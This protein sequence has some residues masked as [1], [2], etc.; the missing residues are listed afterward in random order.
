LNFRLYFIIRLTTCFGP[1]A[2]PPS[3]HKIYK[4]EELYSVSHKI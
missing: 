1:F 4:E 2:V 3:G